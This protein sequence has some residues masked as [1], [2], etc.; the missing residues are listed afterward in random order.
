MKPE[1]DKLTGARAYQSN[2]GRKR[3]ATGRK[4]LEMHHNSI[5]PSPESGYTHDLAE[6][7]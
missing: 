2:S 3:A 6:L 7:S 1:S 5:F 4:Q